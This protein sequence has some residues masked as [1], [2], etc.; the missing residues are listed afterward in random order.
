MITVLISKKEVIINN[1]LLGI[2]ESN[3]LFSLFFRLN[4]K[5]SAEGSFREDPYT[6][7]AQLLFTAIIIA[8]YLNEMRRRHI[9]P[10]LVTAR[11]TIYGFWNQIRGVDNAAPSTAVLAAEIRDALERPLYRDGNLVLH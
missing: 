6:L 10:A 1:T 3:D 11:D 5:A 8:W 4:V 7:S 9:Q 2:T